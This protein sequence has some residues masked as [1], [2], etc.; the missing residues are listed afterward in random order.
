MPFVR[1]AYHP[2]R[3]PKVWGSLRA[4]QIARIDV[5]L[6]FEDMKGDEEFGDYA[7]PKMY[8]YFV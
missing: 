3:P 4:Q 6:P 7:E 5:F 1:A 2:R 8:T